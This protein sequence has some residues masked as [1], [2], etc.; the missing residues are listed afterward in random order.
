MVKILI[1]KFPSLCIDKENLNGQTALIKASIYGRL[2]C[3]R[4]LLKAGIM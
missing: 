2:H 4:L 3:A 1:E